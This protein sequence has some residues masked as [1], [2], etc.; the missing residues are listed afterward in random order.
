MKSSALQ[1]VAKHRQT[2]TMAAH[3]VELGAG[4]MAAGAMD[5]KFGVVMGT[6]PSLL[7]GI[8]IT[9]AGIALEQPHAAAFGAGMVLPHLYNVGNGITA[10]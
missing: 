10:G 6:N 9:V 4:A 2:L 3:A 1:K 8:A 5:G 7:A